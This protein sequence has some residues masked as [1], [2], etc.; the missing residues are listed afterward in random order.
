[1]DPY[2]PGSRAVQ[3]LVGVRDV[4][5]H[6][7]RSITNGIRPIAAAFLELQPM[8]VLAAA[9]ADGR[10]WSTLLTGTPGFARATGPHTISVAAPAPAPG[11]VPV[12]TIALDPRTRRR[13]RLN[14]IARPS[15]RGFTVEAEQVFSN[16]PKY[17][18]K[19][20]L[21]APDLTTPPGTP[22]HGTA[23]TP[24]QEAFVRVADTF[25]I[26]T[27]AA[28]G[29]DASHRGGFPGFVRVV[30]P[31]ELSW[32]DYPGNAMFLTLGNLE[33]DDRA[34]LLFLDW[35]S[36]TTLQLSGTARTAY[37][38]EGSRTTRFRIERIV[39]SPS[40]SPL[41]WSEPEFSPANPPLPEKP[42]EEPA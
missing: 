14:G 11:P 7:G 40:A 30:T 21:C 19:R 2:N 12:G 26:A 20:E 22:F 16:C 15:A 4:A 41:R 23:L 18:Q 36:G 5:A 1:M 3:E 27:T 32:E 39:E 42:A 8:L 6:V 24:A 31:T 35:R 17:I 13:M 28:D 37:G 34:G 33:S 38:P 25:F 9:D 29:T 10:L